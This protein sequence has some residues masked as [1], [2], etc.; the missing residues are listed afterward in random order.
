MWEFVDGV[1]E[2]TQGRADH[3]GEPD[4]LD[5]LIAAE[6]EGTVDATEL[7]DL[8]LFLFVAGYDTSKNQ[9]AHIMNFMLDRP[10]EW[11]R[12]ASDRRYC[13]KVVDEALRHSGVATSYRNVTHDVEY[14]G[15]TLPAGTM[16]I[17]PMGVVCRYSGPFENGLAFDPER[18]N[19]NNRHTAFSRGMHTCLGMFLAKLQIGEGLH[20]I[21]QQLKNPRRDGELVWRL[22]PGVW[23]PKHLPIAFDM[24]RPS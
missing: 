7:R 2:G 17:F 22:F 19:V 9:L 4:L 15:V 21:A 10:A 20:L 8:L 3:P 12:C 1:S 6:S 16:L 13:D 11:L 23:G 14:R 18:P 5:A 24:A